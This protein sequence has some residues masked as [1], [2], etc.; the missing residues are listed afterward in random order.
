[1]NCE[2]CGAK[3]VDGGQTCTACGMTSG[4]ENPKPRQL[5]KVVPF[6]PKKRVP[7]RSA[8]PRRQRP[9]QTTWWIVVIVALCLL[10][11]YLA[12]LVH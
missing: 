4:P 8:K 7:E 1:M 9:N 6:R 5:A 3:V 11:P 10:I 2:H 12:P